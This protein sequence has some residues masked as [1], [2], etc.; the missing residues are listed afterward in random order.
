MKSCINCGGKGEL[1]AGFCE[2]CLNAISLHLRKRLRIG[3]LRLV[4]WERL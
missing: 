1:K 2:K 3:G 4:R